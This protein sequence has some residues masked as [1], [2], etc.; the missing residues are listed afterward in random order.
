MN[1]RKI[2][3]LLFTS[4]LIASTGVYLHKNPPIK[5]VDYGSIECPDSKDFYTENADILKPYID[6]KSLAYEFKGVDLD[7][8]VYDQDIHSRLTN[9]HLEFDNITSIFKDQDN[10]INLEFKDILNYLKLPQEP[11]PDKSKEL[12]SNINEAAELHIKEYPGIFID[13]QLIPYNIKK[14][15]LSEKLQEI[16]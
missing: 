4:L 6:N 2:L 10:W 12:T 11:I 5:M 8:F 13:G 1:E 9:K 15:E 14:S 7:F 16:L 3:F